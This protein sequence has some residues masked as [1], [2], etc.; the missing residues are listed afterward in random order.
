MNDKQ[1]LINK[2]E[3]WTW[4]QPIIFES[5]KRPEPSAKILIINRLFTG[6]FKGTK[7]LSLQVTRAV[8]S[9]NEITVLLNKLAKPK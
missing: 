6:L 8:R 3:N 9:M 4:D 1:R 2:I 5:M 7:E